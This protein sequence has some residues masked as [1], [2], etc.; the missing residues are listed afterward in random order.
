[1]KVGVKGE[2]DALEAS[3]KRVIL[4]DD[5]PEFSFDPVESIRYR[6]LPFRRALNRLFLS[7][8]PEQWQST[9]EDA[10]LE[11][12]PAKRAASA[13]FAEIAKTDPN[14]LLVSL[15]DNFC[16]GGRC[17]F[18]NQSELFYF[19]GDHL[20]DEGAKRIMPIFSKALERP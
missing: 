17:Y 5:Y 19:D 15:K 12:V 6:E 18:A 13:E 7:E 10:A 2:I 8:E 4:L 9:S 3:G 16:A 20:S 11:L 14:L 1:L